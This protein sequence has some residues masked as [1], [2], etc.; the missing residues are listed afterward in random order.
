[1]SVSPGANVN[2]PAFPV[3]SAG[4]VAVPFV[5]VK[6]TETVDADAADSET[7]NVRV[8]PSVMEAG[9]M[10]KFGVVPP[11]APEIA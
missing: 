7:L 6:L 4:A 11:E 3:K 9:A 10:D 2:V 8:P 1:M 5:V